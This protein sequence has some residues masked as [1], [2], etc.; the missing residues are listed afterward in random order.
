MQKIKFIFPL[1]IFSIS[2][3]IFAQTRTISANFN[4]VKGKT[5][6]FYN[7]VVGA[8]RAAEGLRGDWQRDLKIVHDECGFRYIRFHGL[9]HDELGV[10]REDKLGRPIYNF[11]YIDAVYDQ[12]LKIV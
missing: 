8:G 7:E 11:Q 3:N 12:I 4:Q 1:I 2:C 9:L 5:N 6:R 10:Y